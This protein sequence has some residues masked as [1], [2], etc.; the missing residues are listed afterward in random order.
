MKNLLKF[1]WS[2][3][4][5]TAFRMQWHILN[6]FNF[7]L[8]FCSVSIFFRIHWFFAVQTVNEGDH[9]CSTYLCSTTFRY[10]PSV[11]HMTLLTHIFDC[12]ACNYHTDNRWDLSTSK[13]YYL[14]ACQCSEAVGFMLQQFFRRKQWIWTCINFHPSVTNK[15]TNQLN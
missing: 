12:S 8:M 11:L 4:Y 7:C 15:P 9:I 6:K 14:V 3:L 5:Q 13:S 10:L 1:F 2:L